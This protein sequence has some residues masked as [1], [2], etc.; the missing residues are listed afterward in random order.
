M[1]WLRREEVREDQVEA[2]AYGVSETKHGGFWR[3]SRC[4]WT[5]AQMTL[6]RVVM[7]MAVAASGEGD[8][9]LTEVGL[10]MLNQDS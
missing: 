8:R 3:R 4:I 7:R 10:I 5:V 2:V 1:V 9:L 6:A